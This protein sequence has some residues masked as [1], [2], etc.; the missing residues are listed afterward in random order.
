MFWLIGSPRFDLKRN[1]QFPFLGQEGLHWFNKC[2]SWMFNTRTDDRYSHHS[3]HSV[4][5]I[6]SQNSRDADHLWCSSCFLLSAPF[7]HGF[8]EGQECLRLLSTQIVSARKAYERCKAFEWAWIPSLKQECWMPNLAASGNSEGKPW[9]KTAPWGGVI[10]W[11]WL[12]LS[13]QTST[14]CPVP[15]E[16]ES[17]QFLIKFWL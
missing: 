15:A 17:N 4:K 16:Q 5:W 13:I 9:T 1:L 2:Y 14:R 12:K 8:T 10:V 7:P 11:V 6:E 3:S